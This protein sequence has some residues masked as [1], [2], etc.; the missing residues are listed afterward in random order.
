MGSHIETY[1]FILVL[2]LAFIVYIDSCSK[3]LCKGPPDG[4]VRRKLVT[5]IIAL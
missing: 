1:L 4:R 2:A 3:F 5:H